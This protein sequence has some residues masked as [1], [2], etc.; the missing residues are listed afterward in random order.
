MHLNRRC[1][2]TRHCLCQCTVRTTTWAVALLMLQ[3]PHQELQRLVMIRHQ[4]QPL[5]EL[6]HPCLQFLHPSIPVQSIAS[7][8]DFILPSRFRLV[9]VR[10]PRTT[11]YAAICRMELFSSKTV[12]ASLSA[13]DMLFSLR[14]RQLPSSNSSAHT[15]SCFKEFRECR[16]ED[17]TGDLSGSLLSFFSNRW[18]VLLVLL[19][20]CGVCPFAYSGSSLNTAIICVNRPRFWWGEFIDDFR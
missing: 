3:I 19:N 5:R 9:E 7:M 18:F 20:F 6:R 2:W 11:N 12:P 10:W 1:E 4:C 17:D 8:R 14:V 16:F 13:K 15:I